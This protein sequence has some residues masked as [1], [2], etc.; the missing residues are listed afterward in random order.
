MTWGLHRA[1]GFGAFRCRNSGL[2]ITIIKIVIILITIQGCIVE[3]FGLG[4]QRRSRKS[5]QVAQ[6]LAV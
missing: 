3:L 1:L 4:G 5:V 2:I 6:A